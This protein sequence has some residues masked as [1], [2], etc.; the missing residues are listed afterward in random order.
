MVRNIQ[1]QNDR[2]GDPGYEEKLAAFEAR[3]ARGDK[4]EPGD[5]MPA[6]YREQ[7]IRLIQVHANSEICGALPE[8]GWIPH[9][10]SFKRKLALVAPPARM[11]ERATLDR[12]GEDLM[13][14]VGA[15]DDLADAGEL[16]KLAPDLGAHFV[17]LEDTDHFFAADV[18]SLGRAFESWLRAS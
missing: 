4:V 12:F 18:G 17:L 15:N 2:P 9:A 8:G 14:A 3:I 16:E 1:Q 13:I 5:W 11:L 6:K 10:P 7:L